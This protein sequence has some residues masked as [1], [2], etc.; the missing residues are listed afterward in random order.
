MTLDDHERQNGGFY[1]Y[2]GNFG[3]RDRFQKRIAPKLI[4][5]DMEKL[6]R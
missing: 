3:L 4:E 1:G 2:F 6:Q 5:I